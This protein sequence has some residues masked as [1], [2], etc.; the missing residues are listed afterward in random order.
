[1]SGSPDRLEMRLLIDPALLTLIDDAGRDAFQGDVAAR[2]ANVMAQF[3]IPGV[4]RVIV[5]AAAQVRAIAILVEDVSAP[6]PPAFLRRLWHGLVPPRLRD[7]AFDVAGVVGNTDAWLVTCAQDADA[8]TRAAIVEMLAQIVPEVMALQP[9]RLLTSQAVALVVGDAPGVDLATAGAVMTGLLDRGVAI[10]EAALLVSLLRSCRAAGQSAAN[11]L[12]EVYARLRSPSLEI[13][14]NDALFAELAAVGADEAAI[15]VTDARVD[16]QLSA[17]M[18]LVREHRL[19]E[20]GV[21]LPAM[22]VRSPGI[23]DNEIRTRL[24]D[25]IGPPIPVPGADEVGVS[26]ARSELA[27]HGISAR[28]LVDAVTGHELA[29]VPAGAVAAVREIGLLPVSLGGYVAA[30][31]ARAL[32]PTVHRLLSVDR[33]EADLAHVEDQF[34]SLVHGALSRYRL[35][36]ITQLLRELVREQ[37]S[38]QDPWRILNAVLR[39]AELPE[40][41][42]LEVRDSITMH[43]N[44]HTQPDILELLAFV[45]CELRDRICFETGAL[46]EIGAGA[47]S[48]FETDDAFEARADEVLGPRGAGQPDARVTEQ[49]MALRDDVWRGLGGVPPPDPVLLTSPRIRRAL[50]DTIAQELP[51]ARVLSRSEIPADVEIHRRGVITTAPFPTPA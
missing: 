51:A 47:L 16:R 50:R 43:P 22:L 32:T 3:A 1:M 6:F 30:A 36:Q 21:T 24:N 45:R 34:P 35:A 17:T 2:V 20:L 27:E 12:E 18:A 46:E 13:L 10:K 39:Y 14:V 11:T 4:P 26:A 25:R 23:G 29:A 19:V 7:A 8:D 44:N 37:V 15:D 48:V 38:I 5:Q 31:F 49:V 41:V 42:P 9:S 33:V 28:P 40:E